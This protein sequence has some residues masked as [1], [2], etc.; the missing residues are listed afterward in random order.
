MIELAIIAS[1]I[2]EVI[3]SAIAFN[4][5]SSGYVSELALHCVGGSVS[6]ISFGLFVGHMGPI[7]MDCS[8]LIG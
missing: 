6:L 3:G 2:Q 5:L 4:I 1:D 8:F 7:C